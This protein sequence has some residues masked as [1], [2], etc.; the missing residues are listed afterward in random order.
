VTAQNY[1]TR[2]TGFKNEDP[3]GGE[4]WTSGTDKDC[5]GKFHWCANDRILLS[6]ETIWKSGHPSEAGDCVYLVSSVGPMNESYLAN[7]DCNAKKRFL[8][9]VYTCA[10]SIESFY[11]ITIVFRILTLMEKWEC[12]KR[13][14]AQNFG[15]SHQVRSILNS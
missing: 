14:N 1:K 15:I 3:F 9:E 4:F 11:Y 5:P 8:C 6:S 12:A 13:K 2:N 10:I 7:A